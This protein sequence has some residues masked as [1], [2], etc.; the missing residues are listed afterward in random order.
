MFHEEEC[1]DRILVESFVVNMVNK[2]VQAT[3]DY[4]FDDEKSDNSTLMSAKFKRAQLKV[5]DHGESWDGVSF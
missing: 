3:D 5:E 1:P 2:Q 4:D